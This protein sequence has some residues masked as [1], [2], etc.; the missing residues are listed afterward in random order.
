VLEDV[1][2]AGRP[3]NADKGKQVRRSDH[4]A[5]IFLVGAMLNQ[6]VDRNREEAGGK[7]QSREQFQHMGKRETLRG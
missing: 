5:F 1:I 3:S 7:A 4:A 6:R 2:N